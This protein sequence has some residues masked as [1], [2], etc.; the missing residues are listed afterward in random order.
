MLRESGSTFR[1]PLVLLRQPSQLLAPQ[2]SA[3]QL[4]QLATNGSKTSNGNAHASALPR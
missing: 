3:P 2:L 1:L 4:S